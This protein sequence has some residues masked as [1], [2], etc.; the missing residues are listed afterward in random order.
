MDFTRHVRFTPDE[1]TSSGRPGGGPHQ[2]RDRQNEPS[3]TLVL[4]R[5]GSVPKAIEFFLYR[6]ANV[7][8]A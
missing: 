4:V 8:S 7:V 3:F 2:L 5:S 6:P 1:R